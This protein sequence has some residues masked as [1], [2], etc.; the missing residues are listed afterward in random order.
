MKSKHSLLV[1]AGDILDSAVRYLSNHM[2]VNSAQS[3]GYTVY[4]Y[5]HNAGTLET[6]FYNFAAFMAYIKRGTKMLLTVF[7]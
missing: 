2:R 6:A 5:Y 3:S 7:M 4:N 1:F